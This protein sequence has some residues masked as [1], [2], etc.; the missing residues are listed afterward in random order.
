MTGEEL[1]ILLLYNKV[2]LSDLAR[3]MGLS[4]QA[5]SNRLKAAQVKTGFV[6]AILATLSKNLKPIS[7]SLEMM[8]NNNSTKEY[9]EEDIVFLKNRV[10]ELEKLLLEKDLIISERDK[11]IM[12]LQNNISLEH[13]NAENYNQA[14]DEYIE[15]TN[16]LIVKAATN[17]GGYT[18]KQ[19]NL[20]GIGW[21]P[22]KG[23]KNQCVGKKIKK[24]DYE[25]LIGL[26][27]KQS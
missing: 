26:K 1:K 10:V 23:W 16:E 12:L 14:S 17:K 9:K 19:L 6:E 25:L 4:Q 13:C 7:I 2:V 22:P 5:F 24:T 15:L 18:K 27:Y 3:Q 21:P 20:L 11:T 8:N